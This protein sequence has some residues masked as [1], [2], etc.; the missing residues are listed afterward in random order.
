MKITNKIIFIHLV[1]SCLMPLHGM[2][3]RAKQIPRTVKTDKSIPKRPFKYP[4]ATAVPA[5]KKSSTIAGWLT[6]RK[7]QLLNWYKGTSSSAKPNF[8]GQRDSVPIAPAVSI[9][10]SQ[11]QGVK[12]EAKI[13]LIKISKGTP[14]TQKS[15]EIIKQLNSLTKDPSENRGQGTLTEKGYEEDQR[16]YIKIPKDSILEKQIIEFFQKNTIHDVESV[17]SNIIELYEGQVLVYRMMKQDSSFASKIMPLI[18]KYFEQL[19]PIRYWLLSAVDI[20]E[21]NASHIMDNLKLKYLKTIKTTYVSDIMRELPKLL[22]KNAQ[23]FIQAIAHIYSEVNE[24]IVVTRSVY[25]GTTSGWE[26]LK[27]AEK[28]NDILMHLFEQRS[29]VIPMLLQ[30]IESPND[31]NTA[32]IKNLLGRNPHYGTDILKVLGMPENELFTYLQQLL[33]TKDPYPFLNNLYYILTN[34]ILKKNINNIPNFLMEAIKYRYF[35]SLVLNIVSR[36]PQYKGIILKNIFDLQNTHYDTHIFDQLENLLANNS[37]FLELLGFIQDGVNEEI[38]D[39]NVARLKNS[40]RKLIIDPHRSDLK[41]TLKELLYQKEGASLFKDLLESNP[42]WKDFL[43]DWTKDESASLALHAVVILSGVATGEEFVKGIWDL[44]SNYANVPSYHHLV[45]YYQNIE[46][47]SYRFDHF[48]IVTSSLFKDMIT[49]CF[50][51]EKEFINTH[52]V[53]YHARREQYSFLSDIYGMLFSHQ[54]GEPLID[55]IFTHLVEQG[56]KKPSDK[57]IESANQ[58]RERLLKQGNPYPSQTHLPHV[59]K[60]P[61]GMKLPFSEKVHGTTQFPHET[62]TIE[63]LRSFGDR[64][65]LLFLNK[66]LFGN[67]NR[68][69][70]C[71]IYYLLTNLNMGEVEFSIEEIFKMFGYGQVYKKH[72]KKL[73]DLQEKHSKLSPYGEMLQIL[74]PKENVDKCVYY[75]TSGGPKRAFEISSSV[76]SVVETTDVNKIIKYQKEN[77][78]D[79]SEYVLINTADEFGGLNPKSGIKIFSRDLIDPHE[80][81]AFKAEAKLV[82]DEIIES[83][84]EFDKEKKE[85]EVWEK[86]AVLVAE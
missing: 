65:S 58:K 25:G 24:K 28:Y 48:N 47:L 61:V 49:T 60:P 63:Q 52:E 18:E 55:F 78:N 66:F 56:V 46:N 76:L 37:K 84:K 64:Q 39:L 2:F 1:F 9:D 69:G 22:P 83:L 77:P 29:D 45:K 33:L 34:P 7:N 23:L 32:F 62:A 36:N 3:S 26:Y 59:P 67:L 4:A 6:A 8:S 74:I 73:L 31:S 5:S 35:D 85:K 17:F 20:S 79:T 82:F 19:K 27:D 30:E 80:K 71:S 86:N 68:L 75:T 13:E 81:A 16:F 21:A 12:S 50:N 11:P 10:A 42:S 57:F 14:V 41:E 54:S 15:D 72:E 38:V 43:I 40:I 53:F 70:S 51:T 44:D